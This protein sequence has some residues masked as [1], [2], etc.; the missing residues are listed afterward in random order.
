MP[1]LQVQ[2]QDLESNLKML[3]EP[4]ANAEHMI[5]SLT[6][7]M[8]TLQQW[9]KTQAVLPVLNRDQ[10]KCLDIEQATASV[11]D[12]SAKLSS[13][14]SGCH[15]IPQAVQQLAHLATQLHVEDD[16]LKDS[17]DRLEELLAESI[18]NLAGVSEMLTNKADNLCCG[19]QWFV[20][21][22]VKITDSITA[23][24]ETVWH[25]EAKQALHAR[26]TAMY[27]AAMDNSNAA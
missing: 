12:W 6:M 3:T 4:S 20:D 22:K 1:R 13:K 18:R 17:A 5:T 10:Y 27:T 2:K 25:S 8:G 24:T 11:D 9:L 7:Q 23:A 21:E 15:E 26:V 14:P 19:L 16:Q